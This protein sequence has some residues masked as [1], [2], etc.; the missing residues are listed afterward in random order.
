MKKIII[1]L[2]TAVVCNAATEKEIV[3]ATILAEARGEG[4]AGMYGVAAVIAKRMKTRN[5]SAE[6]VCLQKHQFS[7]NN[8]GVQLNLLKTPQAEYALRLA[9]NIDSLQLSFV[10]NATHYHAKSVSPKWAKNQ[11]PVATIGNHIFYKLEK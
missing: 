8:K 10:G 6:K 4:E 9:E 7:C 2:A 11:K 1:L 3:A 5:L